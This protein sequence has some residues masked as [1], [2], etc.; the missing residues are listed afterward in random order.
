M[1]AVASVITESKTERIIVERFR[2]TC[3]CGWTWDSDNSNPVMCPTCRDR[4]WNKPRKWSR[5]KSR[6]EEK[7]QF[8]RKRESRY[9]L[10]DRIYKPRAED[11]SKRDKALAAMTKPTHYRRFACLTSIGAPEHPIYRK[12]QGQNESVKAIT[13]QAGT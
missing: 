6:T 9:P 2:H 4:N 5:H 12:E 8:S 11:E 3:R 7:E 1:P 13:R 10:Y